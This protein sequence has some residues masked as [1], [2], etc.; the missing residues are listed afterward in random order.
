ML[1]NSA[2][3]VSAQDQ[4]PAPNQPTKSVQDID[5]G[6]DD[7]AKDYA[8]KKKALA[9]EFKDKRQALTGSDDWKSL[10]PA[11][12]KAKLK[13]LQQEFKTQEAKLRDDF[14]AKREEFVKEKKEAKTA[15]R[16]EEAKE[17]GTEERAEHKRSSG[18]EQRGMSEGRGANRPE[19][20]HGRR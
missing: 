3:K 20:P 2:P 19:T 1:L 10:S 11:E 14:K 8:T 18:R 17:K 15:E 6:M 12:K 7:P 16:A 9:L 4:P 5:K 13:A